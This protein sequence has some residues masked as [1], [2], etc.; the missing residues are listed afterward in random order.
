MET[1]SAKPKKAIGNSGSTHTESTSIQSDMECGYVL[2][3]DQTYK[4]IYNE[5]NDR[6]LFDESTDTFLP[7]IELL[8]AVL[9]VLSSLLVGIGTLDWISYEVKVALDYGEAIICT[10]FTIEFLARWK[11]HRFSMK[12]FFQPLT[13]VDLL[14]I[15]PG[16]IAWVAFL[17]VSIPE[18]VLEGALINL[19]LLRILRL[20]RVLKDQATFHNFT[21]ALGFQSSNVKSYQLQLVRVLI[22]VYT[23]FSVTAGLIYTAEYTV[24]AS[25][26]DYFVSLYFC[27]ITL[28]SPLHS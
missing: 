21:S 25:F 2:H 19:R 13:I 23:L 11:L 17:G 24:N 4:N 20:Q 9:V 8:L 14:A 28:V 26:T 1:S 16:F 12:Y 7:I 6:Q 18:P 22:S 5:S 15:I 27:I 10:I 3:S